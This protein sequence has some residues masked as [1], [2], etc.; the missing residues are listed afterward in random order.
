MNTKGFW[1]YLRWIVIIILSIFVLVPILYM[2]V[3]SLTPDSEI[4]AGQLLPRHMAI[5]NYIQM[6]KTINLAQGLWNSFVIACL[7]AGLSTLVALG[8][9][10]SLARFRFRGR[11]LFLVSLVGVQAVPH[12]TLLLPLFVLIVIIQNFLGVQ[13]VG[14]YYVVVFTHL[15][16]AL[17]LGCW[18]LLSYAHSIPLELEEAGLVDGCRRLQV[19]RYI[20]FPLMIPGIVVSFVFAFLS[21]WVDV[22]FTS[23]L[24]SPATRTVAIELQSYIATGSQGGGSIYWG[25]L[26]ASNLVAGLPVV[27]IFLI[28]QRY[29]T[30][31]L[32]G[33][34]V[35]G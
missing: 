14:H 35:K 30:G 4:S 10:Y 28:F 8:A 22:L 2:I 33:G 3:V 6:W 27:I 9:A 31:G 34:A 26:M 19:L 24:T 25:Q 11:K 21:S 18:L 15:T 13:L 5:G 29:I 1:V 17:P 32:M 23:V 12:V 7:A 16:F 20:V